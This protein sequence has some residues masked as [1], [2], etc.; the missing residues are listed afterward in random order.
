MTEKL[1]PV[2]ELTYE[3]AL[4]ELEE[5]LSVLESDEGNLNEVLE[6][7]ERGQALIAHCSQLLEK[8]ELKVQQLAGDEITDFE[9]E[10]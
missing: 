6:K 9:P 4:S 7:F 3:Q 1:P 5:L 10:A 8:A 2:E